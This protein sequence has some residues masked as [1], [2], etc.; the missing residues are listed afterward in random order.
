MRSYVISV[1]AAALIVAIITGLLHQ[2]DI[3]AVLVKMIGGLFLAFTVIRPLISLDIGNIGAY[4]AAFSVDGEAAAEEGENIARDAYR[5]YIKSETEAY[6]L[7]K[8][9]AYGAALSVEVTLDD[10]DTPVPVG[11]RIEGSVSPYAK[12]CLCQMMEEDLGILE[13]NQLWIG[14]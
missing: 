14:Q 1:V 13:E 11:V 10:G 4:I 6:I 5:S 2:K 8:A 3:S 9:D 7:D 12:V